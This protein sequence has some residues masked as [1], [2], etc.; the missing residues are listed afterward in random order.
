VGDINRVDDNGSTSLHIATRVNMVLNAKNLLARNANAYIQDH[1]SKTALRIAVE[2]GHAD[3]V[4]LFC[5]AGVDMGADVHNAPGDQPLLI[6][7]VDNGHLEV[8]RLLIKQGLD[9]SVTYKKGIS[10]LHTASCFDGDT[11]ILQLLI[12]S[13]V[14]VNSMTQGGDTA[15]GLAVYNGNL[16]GCHIL[17]DNGA[18][19]TAKDSNGNTAL[20]FSMRDGDADLIQ[21]LLDHGGNILA[22]NNDKVSVLHAAACCTENSIATLIRSGVEIETRDSERNTPFLL[23][24][25]DRNYEVVRLLINAGADMTVAN[26]DG[27]TAI[28]YA[29]RDGDADLIREILCAGGSVSKANF[30]FQTPLDLAI[31]AE[32]PA[33]RPFEKRGWWVSHSECEVVLRKALQDEA[34]AHHAGDAGARGG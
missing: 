34:I 24:V 6:C 19:V 9:A 7:A 12:E 26:S 17:L 3:I 4:E 15:L 2:R 8:T 32:G 13:D 18:D 31:A 27:N 1:A 29:A 5:E 14:D 11:E 16:H 10:A 22:R 30:Y 25:D 21:V 23:A 20:H 28:H 33:I